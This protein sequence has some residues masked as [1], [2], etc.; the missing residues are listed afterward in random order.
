MILM[1]LQFISN[2]KKICSGVFICSFNNQSTSN[3]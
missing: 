2:L 1:D 3:V